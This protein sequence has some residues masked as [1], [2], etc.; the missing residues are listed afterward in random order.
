MRRVR[1]DGVPKS[2]V[3]TI[4][5]DKETQAEIRRASKA[6][7]QGGISIVKGTVYTVGGLIALGLI[8][9]GTSSIVKGVRKN[10]EQR[11]ED[12]AREQVAEETK[13]KRTKTDAWF[14]DAA[15]KLK[16]AMSYNKGFNAMLAP[17]DNEKILQIL[18]SL[19]EPEDWVYLITVFKKVDGHNLLEWLG[20][21]DGGDIRR[22]NKVLEDLGV[23]DKDLI[24]STSLMAGQGQ[25]SAMLII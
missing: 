9:W 14:A 25:P 24:T 18:K 7:V 2:V 22:Y 16:S 6:A 13:N 10:R 23:E 11:R 3:E 1:L 17:Y 20:C 5:S 12:D 8:I 21:D 19:G 4:L 15:Q